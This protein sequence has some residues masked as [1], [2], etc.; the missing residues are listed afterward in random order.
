MQARILITMPELLE[1]MLTSHRPEDAERVKSLRYVSVSS[2]MS[3]CASPGMI[4]RLTPLH[5]VW[6]SKCRDSDTYLRN[7]WYVSMDDVHN[8]VEVDRGH[9][10]ERVLSMLPCPVI[11]LSATIGRAYVLHEWLRGVTEARGQRMAPLVERHGRWADLRLHMH[12][13]HATPHKAVRPYPILR[14][15]A[16]PVLGPSTGSKPGAHAS[17]LV[18][19]YWTDNAGVFGAARSGG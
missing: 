12:V 11:A 4:M 19:E 1:A 9:S 6:W 8:I 2:S 3:S 16:F 13:P 17:A 14:F 15:L 10:Y 18:K 7:E 5:N